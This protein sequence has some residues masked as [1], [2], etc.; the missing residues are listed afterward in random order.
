LPLGAASAMIVLL[1]AILLIFN[2]ENM[3]LFFLIFEN[4]R[5]NGAVQ[6]VH[7]RHAFLGAFAYYSAIILNLTIETPFVIL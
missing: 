6:N 1:I 4:G 7:C 3:R 2:L 5:T